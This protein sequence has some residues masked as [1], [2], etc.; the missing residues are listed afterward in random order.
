[1][2]DKRAIVDPSAVIAKDVTIGPWSVIG[3]NVEIGSGT[4]VG[5]HVIIKQDVRIGKR[6]HIH[7]FASIGGDPQHKA[8]AGETTLLEIGDE[9]DIREFVTLNR[10][11]KQGR[12]VTKMGDRNLLMAYVH[13]AHDCIIG[14]DCV[15][16]NNATLGGHVEVGDFASLGAFTAIHQFCFVGAHSFLSR[17]CVIV[18]DVLPYIMVTGNPSRVKGLNK[19]GLAR[20]GFGE[21]ELE[22]VEQAYRIIFREGFTVSK[23]VDELRALSTESAVSALLISAL[24]KSTRGIVR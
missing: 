12:G 21:K 3:P 4:K 11:S 5:P 22:I 7:A 16:V 10:G 6:T 8:Y 15:F 17:A 9:N 2:I 24:Q 14:N 19:T 13:V 23:A 18:K 20:R 1:M